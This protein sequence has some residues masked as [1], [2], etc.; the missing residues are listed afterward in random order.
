MSVFKTTESI[1]EYIFILGAHYLGRSVYRSRKNSYA[2]MTHPSENQ[3]LA[4]GVL[5]TQSTCQPNSQEL[6]TVPISR[7]YVQSFGV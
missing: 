3:S 5:N 1:T 4:P 6:I 7:L 2:S